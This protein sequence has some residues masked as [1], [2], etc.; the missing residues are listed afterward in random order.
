MVASDDA[1]LRGFCARILGWTND[2]AIDH[3]IHSLDL[4]AD[5]HAALVLLGETDLV[6]IAR[7]LHRRVL[8]AD[9]PFVVCDPRRRDGADYESVRSPVNYGTGV[10]AFDAAVGGSLCVLAR[11]PPRDFS[12][13]VAR[14]RATN[15]VQL[16]VCADGRFDAHPFLTLPVPIRVPSLRVRTDE[17]PKIVDEYASDAVAELGVLRGDFTAAARQWVLKNAPLT[18]AEIEKATLRL[19]AIRASRNMNDA[20]ERLGMARVS[21]TRWIDRRDLPPMPPERAQGHE[22]TRNRSRRRSSRWR[23]HCGGLQ[24]IA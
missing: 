24:C 21:L 7:A 8:G 11:R 10:A 23:M 1:A 12:S 5:H 18:L 20:A 14:I 3:A 16:I 17:L 9:R 6:P 4:A 19:V 22:P 2:A 13:V 15:E